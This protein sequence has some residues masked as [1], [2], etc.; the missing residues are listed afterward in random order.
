MGSS[1]SDLDG[2]LLFLFPLPFG[3]WCFFSGMTWLVGWLL[4][5]TVVVL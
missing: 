2:A 4:T 3:C 1:F 5:L